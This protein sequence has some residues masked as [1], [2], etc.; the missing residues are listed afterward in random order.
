MAG[1]SPQSRAPLVEAL[2]ATPRLVR[3]PFFFPGHKM[4]SVAPALLR[5][6]LLGPSA[7]R[8]DLP[9]LP[10]LGE[11]LQVSSYSFSESRAHVELV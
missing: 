8:Y 9:E 11:L 2:L 3:A 7:F 10:E 4:G 5:R 6:R 1:P